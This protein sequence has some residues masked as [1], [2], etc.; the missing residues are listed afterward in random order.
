MINLEQK[1]HV[2]NPYYIG[3]TNMEMCYLQSIKSADWNVVFSL[4][5]QHR[6]TSAVQ[7][8]GEKFPNCPK[9]QKGSKTRIH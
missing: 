9:M 8:E 6:V 1:I 7:Q 4:L 2:K 3:N 5:V